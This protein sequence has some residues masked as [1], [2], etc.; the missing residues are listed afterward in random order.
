M[1]K[2]DEEQWRT[3]FLAFKDKECVGV[4]TIYEAM[5]LYASGTFGIIQEL[6]VASKVRSEGVGEQL[7]VAAK[8]HGKKYGWNNL[9]VGTPNPEI[10]NRTISFYKRLGFTEIGFRLKH[11]LK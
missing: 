11:P 1:L 6:Y 2:K 8:K 5:A 4:L 10:W 7:I 3:A 9:E